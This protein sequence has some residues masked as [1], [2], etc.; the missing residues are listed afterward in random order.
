MLCLKL[1]LVNDNYAAIQ[2]CTSVRSKRWRVQQQWPPFAV[3]GQLLAYFLND[4]CLSLF[5][6]HR[7]PL[8]PLY[9]TLN[10]WYER[11]ALLYLE[12]L[13]ALSSTYLCNARTPYK[14]IQLLW[15]RLGPRSLLL[16]R[17]DYHPR[18]NTMQTVWSRGGNS[19]Y[20]YCSLFPR[21]YWVWEH[22]FRLKLTFFYISHNAKI[23]KL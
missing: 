5:S 13:W 12:T 8:S 1:T 11:W 16:Y 18:L 9:S 23:V 3:S 15:H 21:Q 2:L 4:A 7:S 19:Q 6:L 14:A 17:L 22:S 10:H 20:C